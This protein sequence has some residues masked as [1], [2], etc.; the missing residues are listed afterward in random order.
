MEVVLL[1]V[2]VGTVVGGNDG[3]HGM[4]L[5]DSNLLVM[6]LAGE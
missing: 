4:V 5:G 2:V 3:G 6:I 1:L